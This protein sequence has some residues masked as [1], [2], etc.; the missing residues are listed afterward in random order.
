MLH[1]KTSRC[2]LQSTG[3]CKLRIFYYITK[4][5]HSNLLSSPPPFSD[6]IRTTNNMLGDCYCAAV[7]EHL[8]RKELMAC[9]ALNLC[10]DASPGHISNPRTSVPELI[11][12][13]LDETKKR[14]K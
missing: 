3:S 9:D 14:L 5:T 12:V 1:C 4:S 6:R 7:V 2:S 10:H 8:S 13:N 11:V